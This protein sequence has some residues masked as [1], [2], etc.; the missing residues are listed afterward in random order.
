MNPYKPLL[1][2]ALNTWLVYQLF[3]MI[4]LPN[5]QSYLNQVT[6]PFVLPYANTLG[7][8]NAWDFFA[9]TPLSPIFLKIEPSASDSWVYPDVPVN[10]WYL[11]GLERRIAIGRMAVEH[12]ELMQNV[13]MPWLC[14][15]YGAGTVVDVTPEIVTISSLADVEHGKRINDTSNVEDKETSTIACTGKPGEAVQ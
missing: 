6:A 8:H 14:R 15:R 12:P 5:Q 13:F 9:P 10:R 4:F 1:K 7:Q 3:V 2:V 11:K